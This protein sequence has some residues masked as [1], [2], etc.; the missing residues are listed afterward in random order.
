MLHQTH[1]SCLILEIWVP[2]EFYIQH[3]H[4]EIQWSLSNAEVHQDEGGLVCWNV[5]G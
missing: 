5:Y 1:S 4:L 2:K 3:A